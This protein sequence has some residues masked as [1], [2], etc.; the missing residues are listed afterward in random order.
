MTTKITKKDNFEAL[1]ALAET[2]GNTALVEFCEHEIELLDKKA[3]AAKAAQAKRKAAGDE[4]TDLVREAL[5]DEFRTI[6]DITL[7]IG[8]E[9]VT[10]AKV[11]YRLNKLVEAG[12]A[13]KQKITIPGADG[14]K[15]R[16]AVAFALV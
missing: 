7:T 14:A 5:T 10:T 6:G 4:I 16:E 12:E 3:A 8:R 9:D 15:G 1:K 11:Q 2:A 13:Q